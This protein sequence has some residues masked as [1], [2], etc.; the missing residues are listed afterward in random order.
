VRILS[1]PFSRNLLAKPAESRAIPTTHSHQAE[2]IGLLELL[3]DRVLQ[4]SFTSK[5]EMSK[6]NPQGY[7]G[8]CVHLL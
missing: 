6:T 8:S 5:G 7:R 3:P 2:A 4:F 1:V